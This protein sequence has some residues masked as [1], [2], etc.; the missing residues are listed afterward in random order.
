VRHEDLVLGRL[1]VRRFGIGF[2]IGIVDN[3]GAGVVFRFCRRFRF[4]FRLKF[5]LR[6]GVWLRFDGRF[7]LDGRLAACLTRRGPTLRGILRF[8]VRFRA[9]F[10]VGFRVTLVGRRLDLLL[11]HFLGTATPPET[12]SAARLVRLAGGQ[13][14]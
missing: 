4:R 12:Q 1:S 13:I 3:F 14:T 10:R 8:R 5:R 2:G 7:G 9:G 6:F 11:D